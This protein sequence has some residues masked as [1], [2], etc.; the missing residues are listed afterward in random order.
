MR[1]LVITVAGVIIIA[2]GIFVIGGTE[3]PST[4]EATPSS[5]T[6]N[7]KQLVQDLSTGKASAQSAS[8][9]SDQLTVTESDN[10]KVTY[11]LPKNEFFLSIAPYINQTHPCTIHNLTGCQ[12][13]LKDQPFQMTIV[14]QDGKVVF[15]NKEMTSQDNGF[16]D[17]WLP[18][19]N[20][21]QV[22]VNYEGKSATSEVSTFENDDTCVATMQLK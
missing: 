21:Y 5:V 18:R 13:E 6:S 11:D 1:K 10:Q 19:D 16:I 2:L 14:D 15:K 12:G 7:I 20:T 4:T 3:Q 9:T 17:L 22:T 8:I